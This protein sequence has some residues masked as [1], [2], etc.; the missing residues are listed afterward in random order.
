MKKIIVLIA[1]LFGLG[2]QGFAADVMPDTVSLIRTNTLGVY[3]VSSPIKIYE[4]PDIKSKVKTVITYTKDTLEPS[5]L[6]FQDVFVVYKDKKDLAVMAVV[7]ETEDWVE[8]IYD[9]KTGAS[10]WIVKDDPYKFATWVNFYTTYGKKYGLYTLKGMPDKIKDMHGSPDDTSKVISVM[11][12]PTKINLN[13]IRGNW[14]LLSILDI[15][16][17]PKTGFVRWRS[18]D[19]VKYFFPAIK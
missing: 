10:G 11:N 15:D 17:T 3:Q 2:L 18:D 14:M 13:I 6:T 8:V 16:K 19:G 5:N 4:N 12:Y 7:D 9:N 1:I